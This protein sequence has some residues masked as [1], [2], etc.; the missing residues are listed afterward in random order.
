MDG[1][2]LGAPGTEKIH[3]F[4]KQEFSLDEVH[5]IDYHGLI[6]VHLQEEPVLPETFFGDFGERVVLPYQLKQMKAVKEKDYVLQSNWKFYV[7]VDMETL[8]TP[9][10]HKESIGDQPVDWE[11]TKG[12]W[13]SVYH[14]S[15][16]TV[17]LHPGERNKGFPYIEGLTGKAAAGTSFSIVYPGFFIVTTVDAMWWIHKVPEG[18]ERTRVHVGYC[19]PEKTVNRDDF[20][21][22]AAKYY[23]RWDQVI[24][25]DDWITEFQQSSI[26]SSRPGRYSHREIVVYALDN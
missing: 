14:R 24:Q 16:E 10:I 13:I 26:R 22:K 25:E 7:E 1:R 5:C 18:P 23:Q 21:S 2:L 19:F 15:D 9:N 11:R 3:H 20:D 8:H 17:A 12:S 4:D 6:F